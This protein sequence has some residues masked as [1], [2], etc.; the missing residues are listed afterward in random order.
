MRAGRQQAIQDLHGRGR[1]FLRRPGQCTAG[2]SSPRDREIALTGRRSGAGH[3]LWSASLISTDASAVP[4]SAGLSRISLSSAA[5]SMMSSVSSSDSRSS[6]LMT[7]WEGSPTEGHDSGCTP[8]RGSGPESTWNLGDPV[9]DL[10][11]VS[12]LTG[13]R[14]RTDV[15]R[16]TDARRFP[17]VGIEPARRAHADSFHLDA[18]RG[19]LSV[20]V[21]EHA[22]SR[23]E[24]EKMAA[25]EIGF[26]RD[27]FGC[28][29]V[30]ESNGTVGVGHH[31]PSG[32]RN[33]EPIVHQPF[34]LSPR[35]PPARPPPRNPHMP[36][37]VSLPTVD[38]SPGC[39]CP[40]GWRARMS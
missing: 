25:S 3:P 2:R 21:I 11:Q 4:G 16:I 18:Q 23:C 40:A 38:W 10:K 34:P 39:A 19:G 22:A 35:E 7:T 5:L 30:R 8:D 1:H 31:R 6:T 27:A 29:P 20:H 36:R 37:G 12:K 26:N 32:Y 33:L 24:V 14:I 28:P 13:R 17:G 9:N 15:Y